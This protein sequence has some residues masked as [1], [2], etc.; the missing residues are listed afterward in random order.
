[1]KAFKN[2]YLWI[3]L[4]GLILYLRTATFGFSNLDDSV[5][6][7]RNYPFLSHI[8]NL[9]RVFTQK[10]FSGSILPYYRP[11]LTVSL[12]LDAHLGGLSPF[13]YHLHNILLHLAASCL[14]YAV[15]NAIGINKNVSFGFALLF[16][17]HPALTPA[18]AWIPGRND[19][20]MAI[21]VLASFLFFVSFLRNTGWW[22]FALHLIFLLLAL[23]TKESALMLMVLAP[24]YAVMVARE[25]LISSRGFIYLAGYVVIV[26]FY[27][28]MRHMAVAGSFE[29][30]WFDAARFFVMYL[31][32]VIQLVGKAV[33]PLNLSVFPTV[34]DT[35]FAY[36]LAALAVI[37]AGIML[38]KSKSRPIIEFGALWFFLFLIPSLIRPHAGVINDVLEHRLYLPMIGLVFIASEMDVIKRSTRAVRY[39]FIAIMAFFIILAFRHSGDFRDKLSFWE[40]AVRTS[41]R[42]PYAHLLLGIAYFE[43]GKD[44]LAE[45]EFKESL[46]MDNRMMRAHYYMGLLHQKDGFYK[47]AAQEFRKEIA[48]HPEFDPSYSSLAVAYYKMGRRADLER[49]WKRAIELNPD[50]LEAYR[51]LAIYYASIGNKEGAYYC[52]KELESR[53]VQVPRDFMDTLGGV[54]RNDGE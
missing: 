5:L 23:F 13:V 6:I 7:V 31:P 28:F 15:F 45:R 22:R 17:V 18:V 16:T 50:N 27:F 34:Q 1:M 33:F 21:F 53:G 41:P 44:A 42:S 20:L 25:K 2:H 35:T 48:L 30:T 52:V 10:V 14:A 8:A 36:G 38:S 12:M 11:M 26:G 24:L 9:G 29:M 51:N 4:A 47:D 19:S 32:A 49:L 3:I 54:P 39:V 40:S 43:D 46:I 37:M